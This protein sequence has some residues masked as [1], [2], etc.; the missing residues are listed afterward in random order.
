MSVVANDIIADLQKFYGKQL[1]ESQAEF[2][3]SQL[4]QLDEDDLCAGIVAMKSREPMTWLPNMQ[5]VKKYTYEAR[6]IRLNSEKQ[7]APVFANIERSARTAHGREA[8]AL[9]RGLNEGKLTR[10]GYLAG[11]YEMHRKYPNYGWKEQAD[12]LKAFWDT[13]AERREIGRRY[14]EMT[15]EKLNSG[16]R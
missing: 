13:E 10:A 15:G 9:I 5:T 11:M 6:D 4:N 12:E 2:W 8:I 7:R 1:N 16:K 14:F 3:R